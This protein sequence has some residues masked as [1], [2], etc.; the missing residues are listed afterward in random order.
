LQPGARAG[1]G[2]VDL[3]AGHLAVLQRINAL[4]SGADLAVGDGLN[5]E[6]VQAAKIGDLFERQR[7]IVDQPDGRRF[8]HQRIRHDISF[9]ARYPYALRNTDPFFLGCLKCSE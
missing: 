8:R 3:A 4:D 1:L 5:F 9:E 6:G 7:R 2:R